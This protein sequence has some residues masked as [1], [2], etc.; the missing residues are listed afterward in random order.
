MMVD[1]VRGKF[2]GL[3]EGQGGFGKEDETLRIVEVIPLG[4]PVEVFPIEEFFAADEID[5][6][7]F[8]LIRPGRDLPEGFHSPG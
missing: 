3:T 2:H 7:S 8:R 5:G 1:D 4:S 6:R